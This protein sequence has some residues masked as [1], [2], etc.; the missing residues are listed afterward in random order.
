M[1]ELLEI[2]CD[3]ASAGTRLDVFLSEV[4]DLT[5]SAS[6]K[7]IE[8]GDAE[9][10][11][12]PA[13]KNYKLRVGDTVT[14]TT[15]EPECIE[16]APEN[17]PIEIVYED[18][19]LIV[20]NKPQGMVVHPAAGHAGGTLVNALLYHAQGRLSAING[21]VRPGI[22]HRIDKD[23]SGILVVAKTNE[24]HLSLAEQIKEHSVTREY[25]CLAC[26][27]FSQTQFTVDKPI[28]RHPKDRKKMAVTEKGG[29]HAITHFTV[30]AQYPGCALLRC[31]LETGRTHQIR[32]HLA[33]LGRPVVGDPVYGSKNDKIAKKYALTG[34]LLH[35][36]LLGFNHPL[37]NAYVSFSAPVP[38][39]F[40]S[41]LT[42][43][44]PNF[45]ASLFE[46][47][48]Q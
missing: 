34:Q 8:N 31:R 45:N 44:D 29:R 23:T 27:T 43:L 46:S 12:K 38:P 47:G 40:Q 35:A 20:V 26:G 39:L 2:L 28:G 6:Q 18:D 15:P 1:E 32:V 3:E 21:V 19:A 14:V 10:N 17:I 36:A 30:L 4:A 25:Y 9:V 33:S 37:T 42:G 48:R 11:G 5:R 7:L 16:A 24:A 13:S 41:V 22:V